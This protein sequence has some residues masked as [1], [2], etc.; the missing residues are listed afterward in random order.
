VQDLD[1]D[2]IVLQQAR[3]TIAAGLQKLGPSKAG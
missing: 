2:R 1:Q 3:S